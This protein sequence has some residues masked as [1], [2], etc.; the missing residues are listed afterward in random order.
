[1][2]GRV[3]WRLLAGYAG[4]AVL[5][6]GVS[7]GVGFVLPGSG[8]LPGLHLPPAGELI[9]LTAV[10][11]L[12]TPLQ[13]AGEEFLFRGYLAQAIGSWIPTRVAALL[14]TA[15]V[16]ALLFALAHGPQDPW[17]FADRFGFGIAASVLVW[18]TGGLEAAIALHALNNLAAFAFST[19]TGT[20][21]SSV[22][23]TDAPAPGVALDLVTL[24]V[25][26]AGVWL[27]TVRRR[28]RTVSDVAAPRGDAG[29]FWRPR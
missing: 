24:T 15:P 29:A 9:A 11:L 27:W 22:T 28:V 2:L 19:L 18:V 7:A 1:V 23:A 8:G 14:V 21:D 12:T 26:T 10:F 5:L 13:A 6:M 16:T 20:L 25:F 17:L 4:F 3:R